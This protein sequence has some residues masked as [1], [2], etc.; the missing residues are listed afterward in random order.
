MADRYSSVPA[1]ARAFCSPTTSF[2]WIHGLRGN[3]AAMEAGGKGVGEAAEAFGDAVAAIQGLHTSGHA[4]WIRGRFAEGEAA[5][6][7]Q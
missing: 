7:A 3:Y 4:A 2:A 5:P 6:P 1:I